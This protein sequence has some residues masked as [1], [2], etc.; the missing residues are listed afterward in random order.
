M[1]IQLAS[2]DVTNSVEIP[3]DFTVKD[4]LTQWLEAQII[5]SELGNFTLDWGIK[6]AG[7]TYYY[8]PLNIVEIEKV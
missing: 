4:N 2:G 3:T 7:G 1:N 5:V 6:D 8:C